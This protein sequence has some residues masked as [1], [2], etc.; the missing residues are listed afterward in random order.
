MQRVET[1]QS[2]G[3]NAEE[4]R[5]RQWTVEQDCIGCGNPGPSIGEHCRGATKRENKVLIGHWYMI[6][7]CPSCDSG[8]KKGNLRMIGGQYVPMPQLWYK[9]ITDSPE[10]PPDEVVS[11]IMM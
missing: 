7:L 8:H 10:Q 2:P 3:P 5:F 9:H 1:R 11:A 6:P 4:K